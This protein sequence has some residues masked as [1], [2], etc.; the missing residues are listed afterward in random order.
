MAIT[1]AS[2]YDEILNAV[3]DDVLNINTATVL[4]NL[5]ARQLLA[6]KQN[7][8]MI[9]L[10]WRYVT[11]AA[12]YSPELASLMQAEDVFH[13]KA[14]TLNELENNVLVRF[15]NGGFNPKLSILK[16]QEI[17]DGRK[18]TQEFLNTINLAGQ[19]YVQAIPQGVINYLATLPNL[20]RIIVSN[21]SDDQVW[22]CVSIK[23]PSP[24]TLRLLGTNRIKNIKIERLNLLNPQQIE[25]IAEYLS[26][27]QVWSLIT[28]KDQAPGVLASLGIRIKQ[29]RLEKLWDMNLQQI[30][31]IAG[32]LSEEQVA[33]FKKLTGFAPKTLTDLG[34]KIKQV[35]PKKI[36]DLNPLE[37]KAVADQ[38]EGEQLNEVKVENISTGAAKKV[39]REPIENLDEPKLKALKVKQ[40]EAWIGAL[41]GGDN[42]LSSR[43]AAMLNVSEIAKMS[44]DGIKH[45]TPEQAAEIIMHNNAALKIAMK[46]KK[47]LLKALYHTA[48][49]NYFWNTQGKKVAGAVLASA[50]GAAI[51]YAIFFAGHNKQSDG[52]MNSFEGTPNSVD[53]SGMD[54]SQANPKASEFGKSGKKVKTLTKKEMQQLR[55]AS[56]AYDLAHGGNS[57][58]A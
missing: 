40:I 34:D 16:I 31:S 44:I 25:A 26:D 50:A 30:G 51:I 19:A 37:L 29:I 4:P 13:I 35:S 47:G 15:M 52:P 38:I 5:N 28:I 14:E 42:K 43:Q 7:P 17:T 41:E 12:H 32:E 36:K 2:T 24:G 1:T 11:N 58:M 9:P 21:L 46:N 27:T 20:I 45:F 39:E 57:G 18:Y 33:G 6:L 23:E 53:V 10:L 3:P 48:G 55:E 8:A 22:F 49:K 56:R 54:L